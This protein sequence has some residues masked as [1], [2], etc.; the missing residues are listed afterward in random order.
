MNKLNPSER[1]SAVMSLRVGFAL[2]VESLNLFS[3]FMFYLCVEIG[4]K[5]Q[6]RFLNRPTKSLRG[7]AKTNPPRAPLICFCVLN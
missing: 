4:S 7:F 6:E 2:F 3:I 5:W 1:A